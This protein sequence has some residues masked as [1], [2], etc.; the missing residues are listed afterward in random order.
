MRKIKTETNWFLLIVARRNRRAEN[1]IFTYLNSSMIQT[2]FTYLH[3]GQ[4]RCEKERVTDVTTD[5]DIHSDLYPTRRK[6]TGHD[7]TKTARCLMKLEMTR[8]FSDN[9]LF[10]R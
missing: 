1:L 3:D 8:Q 7:A 9:A 2:G 5:A 10:Q 6:K 4:K